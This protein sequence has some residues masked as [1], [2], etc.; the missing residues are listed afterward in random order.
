MSSESWHK[1]FKYQ[2]EQLEE[3]DPSFFHQLFN[4]HSKT[5][6]EIYLIESGRIPIRILISM[7]RII[8]WWHIVHSKDTDMLPRVYNVKKIS[9]LAGVKL[10]ETDKKMF[11][12]NF[13][14]DYLLSLTQD[15]FKN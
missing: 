2:I 5:A 13:S 6:K 9:P 12:I 15:E 1:L 11:Y 4:S 10:L 8:Y 7:Y 3:L 14:E